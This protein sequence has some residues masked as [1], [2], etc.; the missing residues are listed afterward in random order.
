MPLTKK[1]KIIEKAMEHEYGNKKG[2]SVFF[3]SKNKGIISGVERKNRI[4]NHDVLRSA[5]DK[6]YTNQKKGKSGMIDVDKHEISMMR[7]LDRKSR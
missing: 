3:A 4:S 5:L 2:K 1:G 7:A 6:S